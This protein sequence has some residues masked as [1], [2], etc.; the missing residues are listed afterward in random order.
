MEKPELHE[1]EFVG[2]VPV[3]GRCTM[4]PYP[5]VALNVNRVGTPDDN[6]ADLQFKFTKHVRRVHSNEEASNVVR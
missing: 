4:C 5:E 2:A 1:I 6:K 3:K